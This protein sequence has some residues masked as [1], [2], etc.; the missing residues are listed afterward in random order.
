[1]IKPIKMQL[2]EERFGKPI[3]A[4]IRD[5]FEAGMSIDEVASDLG[6]SRVT[7]YSWLARMG[8]KVEKRRTVRFSLV[9]S[10]ESAAVA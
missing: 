3:Q 2:V 5:R 9:D 4:L 8:A 10:E 6:I 7:L 1:M